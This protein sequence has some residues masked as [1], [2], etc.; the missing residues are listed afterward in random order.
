LLG[1]RFA[2]TTQLGGEILELGKAI[3]HRQ[4]SR[5]VIDMHLGCKRVRRD[6]R[7]ED[8]DQAPR[9]MPRQQMS[10]A[11]LA[12]LA[13]A[14]LGLVVLADLI[15]SLSHPDRLGLPER[16]CVHRAGG[17]ASAVGAMAVAGGLRIARYDNRDS[18]AEALLG[19]RLLIL[20]HGLS[21]RSSARHAMTL[22]RRRERVAAYG[23][24]LQ[25]GRPA[26]S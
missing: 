15:F 24:R 4:N 11:D 5:L 16:E 6:R 25:A 3:F 26:A 8:I 14:L 21:V 9:R 1:D 10:A 13:I 20:A 19:K 17:P 12:P 7:R 18:T 22:S 23:G 2:G